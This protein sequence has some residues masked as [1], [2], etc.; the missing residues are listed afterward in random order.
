MSGPFPIDLPITWYDVKDQL[1]H[2]Q[3]FVMVTGP[4][5]Y[6]TTPRY[7]TLARLYND[8]RPPIKGRLRWLT[9]SNDDVTDYHPEPTHWARIVLPPK[10]GKD[11]A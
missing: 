1:P 8:Y 7:L 9:V 3:E 10:E 2:D 6:T 4:S 5:G 11:Y